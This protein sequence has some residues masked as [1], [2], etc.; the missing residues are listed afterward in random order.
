MKRRRYKRAHDDDADNEQVFSCDDARV[1]YIEHVHDN[2]IRSLTKHLHSGYVGDKVQ[3]CKLAL[4]NARKRWRSDPRHLR[5]KKSSSADDFDDQD[6]GG[7]FEE[8]IPDVEQMIDQVMIQESRA[9]EADKHDNYERHKRALHV[10]ATCLVTYSNGTKT[11]RVVGDWPTLSRNVPLSITGRLERVERS[12]TG[13]GNNRVSIVNCTRH[14]LG[15]WI[16]PSARKSISGREFYELLREADNMHDNEARAHVK[17]FFEPPVPVTPVVNATDAASANGSGG[18]EA[19]VIYRSNRHMKQS[20]ALEESRSRTH[21]AGVG[22]GQRRETVREHLDRVHS[23]SQQQFVAACDHTLRVDELLTKI[24]RSRLPLKKFLSTEYSA[25]GARLTLLSEKLLFIRDAYDDP[26]VMLEC[27]ARGDTYVDLVC[28]LLEK[29]AHVLCFRRLR[30]VRG[31]KTGRRELTLLPDLSVDLYQALLARQGIDGDEKIGV[32]VDIYHSIMLR[33]VFGDHLPPQSGKPTSGH[34]FSVFG[35]DPSH[36]MD[37][38][39]H[40]A[41][42]DEVNERSARVSEQ[43]RKVRENKSAPQQIDTGIAYSERRARRAEPGER[44]RDFNTLTHMGR[45]LLPDRDETTNKLPDIPLSMRRLLLHDMDRLS[46]ECGA[47]VF[48]EALSWLTEQDIV[49]TEEHVGSGPYNNGMPFTAFYLYEIYQK[50][51]QVVDTLVDIHRRAVQQS[52]HV[53][54]AHM[55]IVT[56]TLSQLH[57]KWCTRLEEWR[58]EYVKALNVTEKEKKLMGVVERKST[59]QS[60]SANLIEQAQ[61]GAGN[62]NG[63]NAAISDEMRKM[64]P[65]KMLAVRIAKQYSKME[66]ELRQICKDLPYDFIKDAYQDCKQGKPMHRWPLLSLRNPDAVLDGGG[67][68][69]QEQLDAIESMGIEGITLL[70]GRGGVGKTECVSHILKRYAPEQV[71]CVAFTGQVAS[72]L[73]R[74]TGHHAS[75]IHSVLFK[76]AKYLQAMYRARSYRRHKKKSLLRTGALSGGQKPTA[77][78]GHQFGTNPNTTGSSEASTAGSH[79]PSGSA[80]D[81]RLGEEFDLNDVKACKDASE[82]RAFV[83]HMI[84]CYPP[85]TSPLQDTRVL[86]VDEVS[87]LAFPLLCQLLRAAHCP[88]EGRFIER[89]ILIGDLDQLPAIGYGNVQSDLAHAAPSLVR[90]LVVNHRSTGQN[91]FPL[92]EALGEHRYMLPLPKFEHFDTAEE[93]LEQIRKSDDADAGNDVICIHTGKWDVRKTIE[94]IYDSMG[95]VKDESLRTSIQCLAG[96]NR[97][98]ED[99]NRSIRWLYFGQQQTRAYTERERKRRQRLASQKPNGT[100]GSALQLIRPSASTTNNNND[101]NDD[102]SID[103]DDYNIFS[104]EVAKDE[105]DKIEAL[106]EN[107]VRVGDVVYL[108]KNDCVVYYPRDESEEKREKRFYNQRRLECI[109]FYNAP[110]RLIANVLCRCGRCQPDEIQTAKMNNSRTPCMQRLDLVPVRRRDRINPASIAK[111]HYFSYHDEQIPGRKTASRRLGVFRDES[112]EFIEMDVEAQLRPRT[113][114]GYG[115]AMTVH[116]MQG[117][118]APTIVYI[119][120]N[121]MAMLNWKHLYTA[122]TRARTRVIILSTYEVFDKLARRRDPFRRSSIWF[123]LGQ[124]IAKT[125]REYPQ[126]YSARNAARLVPQVLNEQTTYSTDKVWQLFETLRAE[127]LERARTANQS[128][129]SATNKHKRSADNDADNGSRKRKAKESIVSLMDMDF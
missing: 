97:E 51:K 75:T 100:L 127:T 117:S 13:G 73:S 2:V 103:A 120:T 22:A 89:L 122:V 126:S 49:L 60:T 15:H 114:Y 6:L 98:V 46:C 85:F 90:Q 37:S 121:P 112:G 64:L 33:D 123:M 80:V 30:T 47:S 48:V 23:T 44:L 99:A 77:A 59:E 84:E 52:L 88:A 32:A 5:N 107:Q 61:Q 105:R 26:E 21:S 110:R 74:R 125:L 118:Q 95:C 69:C 12:V 81:V 83:E 17:R 86:I 76:H 91:I 111:K 63:A 14:S 43:I 53:P 82:L 7:V 34:M 31:E 108:R 54:E 56:P 36:F 96:T 50:Q 116:K 79:Q 27:V 3:S 72:E 65:M 35:A 124:R 109:Q 78:T 93:K 102:D 9:F 66:S 92:A 28:S 29:E 71:C 58:K 57:G 10:R 119:C 55:K 104:W 68:Y 41:N 115:F 39:Y 25:L 40:S 128:T 38:Y 4:E 20:M 19:P 8:D 1:A 42:G 18:F 16:Q 67:S 113:K 11:A 62:N 106:I 87:L 24:K 70:T 94:M 129:A 101:S 45:F